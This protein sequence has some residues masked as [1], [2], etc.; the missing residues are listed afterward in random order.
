M[1]SFIAGTSADKS[2]REV[3]EYHPRLNPTL[4]NHSSRRRTVLTYSVRAPRNPMLRL[5]AQ[6][7]GTVLD[8]ARKH[9]SH[10]IVDTSGN[11]ESRSGDEHG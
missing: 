5:D 1:A 7:I 4:W 8:R 6:Q 3:V 2:V 10:L 9:Y 11:F